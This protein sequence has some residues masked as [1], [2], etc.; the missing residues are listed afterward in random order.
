MISTSCTFPL[1]TSAVLFAELSLTVQILVQTGII[2]GG[3]VLLVCGLLSFYVF[4][5]II[6]YP[7]Q[8]MSLV[9]GVKAVYHTEL[10]PVPDICD[11]PADSNIFP[12]NPYAPPVEPRIWP[13][14]PTPR[15][16]AAIN[17][18][19]EH[20]FLSMGCIELAD[21]SFRSAVWIDLRNVTG[22]TYSYI[23]GKEE[24]TFATEFTDNVSLQTSDNPD[25]LMLPR[26]PHNWIQ[27]F[28]FSPG[29]K[30]THGDGSS[31][32]T[33]N[34]SP[35]PPPPGY[36][37]SPEDHVHSTAIRV[38]IGRIDSL[39]KIH[40]E[41]TRS[42]IDHGVASLLPSGAGSMEKYWKRE[43]ISFQA[44]L[45]SNDLSDVQKVLC[46]A[47]QADIREILDYVSSRPF[48]RIRIAHWFAFRPKKLANKTIEEQITKSK[49]K[50]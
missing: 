31:V 30:T 15:Y 7:F 21:H 22:F 6:S 10:I 13:T 2:L 38:A 16:Q 49:H 23:Q 44:A 48:W 11:T 17:W 41:G 50:F 27:V 42:L 37:S 18:A 4:G 19:Q 28:P 32:A 24:L 25:I 33:A 1:A 35:I 20:E 9:R 36:S 5:M 26:P 14:V 40:Q 3:C 29:K 45:K 8:C 12:L 46:S 43:D 34:P 47:G 39:Y